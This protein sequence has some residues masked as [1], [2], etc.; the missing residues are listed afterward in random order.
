L[1]R[2]RKFRQNF[3]TLPMGRTRKFWQNFDYLGTERTYSK[4]LR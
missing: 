2:S 3:D 4:P 1:S